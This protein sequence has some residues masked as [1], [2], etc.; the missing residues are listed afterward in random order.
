MIYAL[1]GLLVSFYLYRYT[2]YATYIVGIAL[3]FL[4]LNRAVFYW[5]KKQE[6]SNAVMKFMGIN[7]L[8][9][10]IWVV[11]WMFML[12]KNEVITIYLALIFL[13]LSVPLYV[14][15]IKGNEK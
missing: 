11:F 7:F 5:Y 4:T 9:D 8:K 15:V 2:E 12:G 3:S 13:M 1:V 14:S 6:K 10:F